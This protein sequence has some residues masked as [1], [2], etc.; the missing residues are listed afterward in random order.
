MTK[1]EL[2]TCFFGKGG[3]GAEV[4]EKESGRELRVASLEWTSETD[5]LV[6]RNVRF[7]VREAFANWSPF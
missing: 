2:Q 7:V 3:G 6:F 5:P 4:E 1:L